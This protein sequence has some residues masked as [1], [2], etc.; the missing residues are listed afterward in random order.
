MKEVDRALAFGIARYR[1]RPAIYPS[2]IQLQFYWNSY[3]IFSGEPLFNSAFRKIDRIFYGNCVKLRPVY[4]PF[5]LWF[6]AMELLWNSEMRSASKLR[7]YSKST[8]SLRIYERGIIKDRH[9]VREALYIREMAIP[10]PVRKTNLYKCI[11]RMRY[12]ITHNLQEFCVMIYWRKK[13]SCVCENT[14]M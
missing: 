3:W 11:V 9:R 7:W 1:A 4:Q 14:I 2:E 12:N 6:T 10:P 13:R 8:V 5:F